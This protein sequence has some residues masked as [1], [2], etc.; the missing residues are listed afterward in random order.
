MLSIPGTS[1]SGI[2]YSMA[3]IGKTCIK[4]KFLRKKNDGNGAILSFLVQ[5]FAIIPYEMRP[6]CV[7]ISRALTGNRYLLVIKMCFIKWVTF[8][9]NT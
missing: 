9:E 7:F 1:A 2:P 5:F 4:S 6:P 3:K 8:N